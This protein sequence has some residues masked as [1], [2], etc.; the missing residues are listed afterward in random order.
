MRRVL[1]PALTAEQPLA[2][3]WVGYAAAGLAP[4]RVRAALIWSRK[5]GHRPLRMLFTVTAALVMG[6]CAGR[7]GGGGEGA[8]LGCAHTAHSCTLHAHDAARSRRKL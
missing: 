6:T 7:G 8:G 1:A 5:A 3:A 4:M 2:E